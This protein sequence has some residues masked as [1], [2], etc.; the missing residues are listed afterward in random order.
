MTTERIIPISPAR[1]P[2]RR[3]P[4]WLRVRLPH[5]RNFERLKTTMR[6]LRL[7]TV[8]E[9]ALCPNVGECWGRGTATFMILG[10]I[11]T[12]GCRYCAV[13]KGHP[14]PLDRDEPGRVGEAAERMG[15]RHVVLTSVDRDDLEDG[16]AEIFAATIEA[17]RRRLPECRVEVLIPDFQGRRE[18]LEAVLVAR[19]DVLNHNIET[20][21]R[22]FPTHRLGGD[23]ALSLA[24]LARSRAIAPSIP[25]KSGMMLGMGETDDEVRAV[26]GD[27]LEVGVEILTLGQYLQPGRKQAPVDRYLPPAAFAAWKRLGESM[28]FRHVES[29]PLVRSSYHAESQLPADDPP[30]RAGSSDD[31]R[32]LRRE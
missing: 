11:C 18:S 19:P 8:C 10:D 2:R 31:D 21:P 12:R 7:H 22:L 29:G 3:H 17:I 32:T 1:R 26:L 4:E 30:A 5:G 25:T 28:G 20:V 27:L 14:A 9:E 23:Y 13:A 24:L 6:G 16:G 15:L